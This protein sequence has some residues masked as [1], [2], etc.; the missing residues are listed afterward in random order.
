MRNNIFNIQGKNFYVCGGAKSVDKEYRIE[1]VTW[2]S[3]ELPT[4]Q[5]CLDISDFITNNG[6][7]VDYVL[8]HC[9]PTSYQKLLASW[10]EKDILT[11]VLDVVD[12]N[13]PNK[14]AWYAGHFHIDKRI[15]SKHLVLYNSVVRLVE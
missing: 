4:Y 14:I 6:N 12:D 13:A 3:S 11:D 5:D 8:S 1:G 7:K 9:L 10:Y 15:D 2:W